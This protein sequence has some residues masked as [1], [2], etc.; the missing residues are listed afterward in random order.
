MTL[1]VPSSE[2]KPRAIGSDSHSTL[3]DTRFALILDYVA[4]SLW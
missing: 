2:E 3:P 1:T 4:E